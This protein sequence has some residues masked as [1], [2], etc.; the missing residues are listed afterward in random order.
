[1]KF[2]KDIRFVEGQ[3]VREVQCTK[4]PLLSDAWRDGCLPENNCSPFS[5]V[6]SILSRLG[7]QIVW[8]QSLCVGRA[9]K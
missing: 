5:E 8:F 6:V 4:Q 9:G 2:Q 3:G 7:A 1:M